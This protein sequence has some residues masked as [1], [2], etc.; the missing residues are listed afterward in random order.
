MQDHDAEILAYE[1]KLPEENRGRLRKG[2]DLSGGFVCKGC[3]ERKLTI[4]E[5]NAEIVRLKAKIANIEKV[6]RK[7]VLNAHMPSSR[8]DFKKNS[9]E[10]FRQKKGGAKKGHKGAGRSAA[11][12]KTADKIVELLPQ[13]DSCPGCGGRLCRFDER[14][15]TVFEAMP[16]KAELVLYRA[17]RLRCQKCRKVVEPKPEI[18]PRSLYGN[19]LLTQSA[20]MHYVHGVPIGRVLSI[21]GSKVTEGGIIQA[22]HR[23][24]KLFEKAL[25]LLT[26][27]YRKS[28][29]RHADETGWRTDGHSG[30]AW[31]F[32][33]KNLSLLEFADNRSSRVP[34]KFLGSDPLEGVLIVHRYGGYN[35]MP[36]A[37]Q[38]CYAHL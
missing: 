30:Y 25:P 3:F 16:L 19:R 11:T 22:F 23:L 38:Y 21:V 27:E 26:N 13:T 2:F 20:V 6:T 5:Q 12:D 15:R 35:K 7:D 34:R 8:V 37:L 4:V 14:E 24:G 1:K 33:T 31:L 18:L 28:L 29:V 36:V 32:A 17:K 10:D 9:K